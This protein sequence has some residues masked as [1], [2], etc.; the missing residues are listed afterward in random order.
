MGLLVIARNLQAV[1][2]NPTAFRSTMVDYFSCLLLP[3]LPLTF[4]P[5]LPDAFL[6][7]RASSPSVMILLRLPR[8]IGSAIIF[9]PAMPTSPPC[10]AP[11]ARLA[12]LDDLYS[13]LLARYSRHSRRCLYPKSF[14][15]KTCKPTSPPWPRVI[16]QPPPFWAMASRFTVCPPSMAKSTTSAT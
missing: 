8:E 5:A 13:H 14:P 9:P 12:R 10:F 1:T 4:P 6:R 7:L 16:V 2:C 11:S 3:R 15:T